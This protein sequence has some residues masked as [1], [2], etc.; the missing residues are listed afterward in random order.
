MIIGIDIDETITCTNKTFQ[1]YR[2][3]YLKEKKIENPHLNEEEFKNFLKRYGKNIYLEVKYKKGAIKYIN[4][5]HNEHYKIIFITRRSKD[6]YENMEEDTINSLKINKVSYDDIIFNARDKNEASKDIK[7][8]FYID[9]IES[10]LD[11]FDN[12]SRD[13]FLIKMGTSSKYK[14]ASSWKEIYKIIK[15]R[16]DDSWKI[17]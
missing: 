8:D 11:D 17:E 13:V 3:K 16:S 4:K 9:D 10:V 7:L 1:K 12:S 6:Y 5:L 14:S 2:N 15:E